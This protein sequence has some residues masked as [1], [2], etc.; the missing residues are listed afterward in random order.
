[1]NKSNN[2]NNNNNNNS[3]EVYKYNMENAVF[4]PVVPKY[5][6]MQIQYL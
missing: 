1:M 5:R 2:N 3:L 4:S 6:N